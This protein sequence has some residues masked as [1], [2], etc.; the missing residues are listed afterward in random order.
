[1]QR[2][3]MLSLSLLSTAAIVTATAQPSASSS[4]TTA[5]TQPSA[6]IMSPPT[7]PQAKVKNGLLEGLTEPSGVHSFKG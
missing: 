4:P 2:L 1:M 6:N 3:V 5:A 7:N